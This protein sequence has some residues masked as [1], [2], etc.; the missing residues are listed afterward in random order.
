MNKISVD[1]A[2]YRDDL[3]RVFRGTFGDKV[4]LQALLVLIINR[5]LRQVSQFRILFPHFRFSLRTLRLFDHRILIT[6]INTHLLEFHIILCFSIR[7]DCNLNSQISDLR[8]K[9]LDL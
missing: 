3:F 1:L 6:L 4:K 9:F 2:I 7:F 5:V 8:I